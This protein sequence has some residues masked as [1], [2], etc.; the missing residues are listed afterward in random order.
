MRQLR[1]SSLVVAF[2]FASLPP[3]PQ[4]HDRPGLEWHQR[5]VA[6]SAGQAASRAAARVDA[7]RLM[8]DLRALAAPDMEGRLTGS[9]GWKR[10]QTRILERF[11]QL[12]L[13]PLNGSH[14]QKFSFT[15]TRGRTT[16]EIPDA[17]NLM[18]VVPGTRERDQYVLVTAHYDHLGLRDGRTFHGADDNASGVAALLAIAQWFA[19]NPAPVSIGFVAFDAEEQGLRGARHF[20]ASP[21]IDLRR[22]TAVVNMDMI[23]RGDKNVIFVAGTSRFPS[24]KAPVTAAA[25]GRPITVR[26]GHD[27]PGVPGEDDWTNSS[28]HGAFVGGGT[29]FLYFGV[30][31]H[32]DYHQPSDTADKIPRA[33]FVAA[34]E[35]VLD[36][37]RR[38]ADLRTVADSSRGP[39]T[40]PLRAAGERDREGGRL[41]ADELA[42]VAGIDADNAA[43]LQLLER[44]VNINSGTMNFAGVREV[45]EVF[46]AE[47]D[48]LGFSTRWVDGASFKRAGHLVADRKGDG[49]RVLLIG[50]LDTVFEPDSPFQ[51]FVRL[52][53]RTARG[54]GIIDMKGGNVVMVQALKAL[55]RARVLD[56]L[57]LTVVMTGDEE[58]SG[59]PLGEARDAL[60]SAAR[61]A[62]I[63]LGFE[64]G[65]GD[66][67][68]AVIARRGTSGWHL[69]VTAKPAHASQ[70]FREDVGYGAIFEAARI[71]NAFRD[72]LAGEAHLT[73]NPGVMLGGTSAEIDRERARGSASGKENVVAEQA[74]VM[75]DLRALSLPQLENARNRMRE[76][77]GQSLPHAQ[78]TISFD[79]GYPP[80]APSAGNERLLALYDQASRD[81]GAGPVTA[82]HPDRAGAADVAFVAGH[83]PMILDGIGLMGHSDHT[84]QETADLGT[85]PSQTKR[86]A[87]LLHRIGRG[88]ATR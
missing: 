86:A 45:G 55:H 3:P 70:V 62:D 48:R 47:L 80:L 27:R 39:A 31:D 85:L 54:P 42:V 72:S 9:A 81:V 76:I 25:A 83:V 14:E 1:L 64:D 53:E 88:A 73:F 84:P 75:G 67:K 4:A 43:G 37:V 26:F 8:D 44:A 65:P 24:L 46:R 52:D 6:W 87:I 19:A 11:K 17:T 74:V 7:T 32:A 58:Q 20:V 71:L 38:I 40:A 15:R 35:L 56:R 33:F 30:E 50:H 16:E 29:P 23:G 22:I 60:V 69:R 21:P 61:G 18:G 51:K 57:Q 2:L 36:T 13:Q 66:P 78:A 49:P 68:T 12:G 34:T 63:A 79:D 41:T 77:V 28:D 59:E 82:V 5:I 10:A